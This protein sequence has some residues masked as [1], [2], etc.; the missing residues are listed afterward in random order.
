MTTSAEMPDELWASNLGG[1]WSYATNAATTR[2]IRV[3][4]HDAEIEQL[5]T[6]IELAL[7]TDEKHRVEIERLRAIEHDIIWLSHQCEGC[8]R[9]YEWFKVPTK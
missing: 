8:G 9:I 2:Y 4:L 7:V 6:A 5:N 1:W 3:D